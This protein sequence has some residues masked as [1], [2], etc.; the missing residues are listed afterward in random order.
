MWRWRS[1]KT[2]KTAFLALGSNLG[3]RLGC[4]AVAVRQLQTNKAMRILQ[5][6]SVYETP[7]VGVVE[8][9]DFLNLVVEVRTD[10]SAEHLLDHA[11][12][13]EARLGRVRR[14]RWGPR[15]ID[16]DLLWY[17]GITIASPT[18]TLPHPRLMERAFV[19]VP[20]AEIAP[21]LSIG[22]RTVG[23]QAI[24][25]GDAAIKNLGPLLWAKT[26]EDTK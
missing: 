21:Q 4:L 18:L 8:Q 24:Q 26:P 5:A 3:D 23:E 2:V 9:P 10:L 15:T 11:L 22:G 7:P 14:E 6:S 19:V 16:I 25:L 17:E 13:V 12:G 20:L 1:A